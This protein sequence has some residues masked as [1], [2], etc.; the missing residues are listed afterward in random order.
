M[1][2]RPDEQHRDIDEVEGGGGGGGGEGWSP[3]DFALSHQTHL[4]SAG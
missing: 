3:L 4:M 2:M 1:D